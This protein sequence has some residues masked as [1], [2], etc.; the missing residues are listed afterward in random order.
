MIAA[1][2]LAWTASIGRR[3]SVSVYPS[4]PI[5][6]ENLLRIELQFSTP[7]Y[8]PLDMDYVH[9]VD[10]SGREIKPAF[11]DLPLP[12]AD[13]MEVTLLLDPARVKTGV[14]AN[15]ALGRCLRAGTEVTLLIDDPALTEPVRKTWR[16]TAGQAEPP[17][18]SHWAFVVPRK[19]TR[20]PLL[21]RLNRPISLSGEAF[22][23]IRD[24]DGN[25]LAGTA[26]LEAGET[27]WRFVPARPWGHGKHAI[28]VNGELED[29]AGNRP[30][31]PFEMVGASRLPSPEDFSLPFE[32][33]G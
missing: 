9:L 19:G 30:G 13:G 27:V 21:V 31:M 32:P 15:L 6:P 24:P 20:S 33:S 10:G 25:R 28:V 2:I 22:I 26:G 17:D 7:F 3:P 23:A 8:A 18:P 1:M 4:G 5:V 12:S 14:G 11:L 16:V 29:P